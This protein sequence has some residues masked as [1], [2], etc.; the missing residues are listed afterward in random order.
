[1]KPHLIVVVLLSI[2]C[3]TEAPVLQPKAPVPQP[4]SEPVRHLAGTSY[5]DGRGNLICVTKAYE[6]PDGSWTEIGHGGCTEGAKGR[7]P[8][9]LVSC[10]CKN[11]STHDVAFCEH[12]CCISEEET[13]LMVCADKVK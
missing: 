4:D 3:A 10:R 11:G 7:S 13:C 12:G 9:P 6:E 1:M 2:S 8:C 5:I